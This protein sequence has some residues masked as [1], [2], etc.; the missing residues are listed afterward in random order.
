MKIVSVSMVRNE[1]D[2]IETFVRYHCQIVDAMIVVDHSSIDE[3]PRILENLR[4]EGLPLQLGSE[5]AVSKDHG[6]VATRAGKQAVSIHR[7]DLVIPLDADEFL[8]SPGTRE[9]RAVLNGLEPPAGN[10]VRIPWITYVPTAQDDPA[11]LNVL[12]RV[13]HRRESEP[14]RHRKALIPGD[15]MR[16]HTAV[17]AHGNHQ[18]RTYGRVWKRRHPYIEASRL[19][20]AHFPVRSPDQ[21]FR[22][23]VVG[24][25]SNLARPDRRVGETTHLEVLYQRFKTGWMPSPDELSAA[26]MGYA[27][28]EDRREI[29]LVRDPVLPVG[30]WFDLKCTRN[31]P[32]API[33]VLTAAAERLAKAMAECTGDPIVRAWRILQH[34]NRV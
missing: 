30:H 1:A 5:G 28:K 13:L 15:L 21:L 16:R 31:D 34:K 4:C 3:T 25:L 19:A 12:K 24:W 33:V 6:R 18:L 22:K 27:T 26:A 29:A 2:I 14:I 11:E 20:L 7:A 10:Y 9:V 8:I 17:L 23:V 32:L